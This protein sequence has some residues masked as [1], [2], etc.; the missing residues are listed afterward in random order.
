MLRGWR[1]RRRPGR[2]HFQGRLCR[3]VNGSLAPSLSRCSG[4][5]GF[6]DG[7][8]RLPDYDDGL[9]LPRSRSRFC[10]SRGG[11]RW[12]LL[13][14]SGYCS[15]AVCNGAIPLLKR[16]SLRDDRRL[17][18]GGCLF[19]SPFHRRISS[20]RCARVRFRRLALGR[21]TGWAHRDRGSRFVGTVRSAVGCREVRSIGA[22]SVDSAGG[23]CRRRWSLESLRIGWALG[24]VTGRQVSGLAHAGASNCCRGLLLRIVWIANLSSIQ[25]IDQSQVVHGS[26]R[27]A[28]LASYND[29]GLSHRGRAVAGTG[30][31]RR[32]HVLEGVPA[33][34]GDAEG[35][36]ISQIGSFLGSSSKDV[37]DVVDNRGCVA[38]PRNRNITDALE[39]RP[40]VR[41]RIVRPDVVKPLESVGTAE[42]TMQF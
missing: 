1:R 28:R 2:A 35:S 3:A 17:A 10:L 11:S 7:W 6:G 15:H 12:L 32:A 23:G 41:R 24:A 5:G 40:E 13:L 20:S 25:T 18:L 30:R 36:Q 29:D 9:G 21:G 31:G 14:L 8:L 26:S 4:F 39:L 37:H 16:R 42:A 33:P 34:R 38:L 27:R 19:L 22:S